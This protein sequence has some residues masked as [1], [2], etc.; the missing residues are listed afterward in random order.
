MGRR[1]LVTEFAIAGAALLAGWL[2][3]FAAFGTPYPFY[4][5]ASGSMIPALE[6]NDILLVQGH[7]TID[8]VNVGDIIVFDRPDGVDRVIVHRIVEIVSEDPRVLKTQGDAN[9]VSIPGTDYPITEDDYIGKVIH[10]IP[11]VGYVTKILAPPINYILIAA[12][13][14]FMIYKHRRDS[15]S[16]HKPDGAL[17]DL[18]DIPRDDEYSEKMPDNPRTQA[19]DLDDI[20]R[21]DEY[22]EKMPD[23]PRTQA[24]DLDDI[25]RDDDHSKIP[26]NQASQNPDPDPAR[27]QHAPEERD[28]DPGDY[29]D[30]KGSNLEN[31]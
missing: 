3:L 6:V 15:S 10:V 26:K 18:D 30:R 27:P 11:K 12:I 17:G 1:K 29:G 16:G 13:I 31:R 22:S 2:V 25:P 23:N 4:V 7:E 24:R 20:P 9:A 8:R 28:A 14:G 5:V 19:R 21:D